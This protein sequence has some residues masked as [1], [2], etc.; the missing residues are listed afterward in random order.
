MI[1]IKSLSCINK[2]GQSLASSNKSL[3]L[4]KPHLFSRLKHS[5]WVPSNSKAEAKAG[6]PR[7]VRDKPLEVTSEMMAAAGQGSLR[8]LQL[9]R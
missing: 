2:Q 7:T 3:P 6:Q 9:R 5:I 8:L 4:L 1:M